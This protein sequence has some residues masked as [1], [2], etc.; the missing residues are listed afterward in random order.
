MPK[1]HLGNLNHP[2]Q[3]ILILNHL[4]QHS[5]NLP[6][7]HRDNLMDIA[8]NNNNNNNLHIPNNSCMEPRRTAMICMEWGVMELKVMALLNNGHPLIMAKVVME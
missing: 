8:N 2:T 5:L 6:T 3:D 1:L 7:L 4:T